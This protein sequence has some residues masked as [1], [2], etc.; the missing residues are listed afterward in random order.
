MSVRTSIGTR[1]YN[2]YYIEY[3]RATN[4]ITYLVPIGYN[5]YYLPKYK[6]CKQIGT[7]P[8]IGFRF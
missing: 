6:N 1:K 5:L 8:I 4:I 7:Y 3:I 2:N